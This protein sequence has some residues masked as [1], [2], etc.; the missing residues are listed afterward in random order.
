MKTTAPNKRAQ[1]TD[2]RKE[3][4]AS[5]IRDN[6]VALETAYVIVDPKQNKVIVKDGSV[7]DQK[8]KT[9]EPGDV[10]ALGPTRVDGSTYRTYLLSPD[11]I[12]KL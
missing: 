8:I 4:Y 11:F 5:V 9:S 7:A 6:L 3:D 12:K 10:V 1:V 2:L